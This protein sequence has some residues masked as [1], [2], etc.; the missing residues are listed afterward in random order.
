MS[1]NMNKEVYKT[2]DLGLAAA[3]SLSFPTLSLIREKESNKV[4]FTFEYDRKIL[5][6]AMQY[7]NGQLTVN[8]QR[9]FQQ[10]KM[11]KTR[12]YQETSF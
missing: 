1:I 4:N 10:L 12:I 11:L 5:D 3:I 8:P 7:W 6:L 9:Y 2:S